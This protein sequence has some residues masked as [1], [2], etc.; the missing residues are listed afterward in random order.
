MSSF[1]KIGGKRQF[2]SQFENM[3]ASTNGQSYI[4]HVPI[5]TFYWFALY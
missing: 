3:T 1:K 2:K 5:R 4:L